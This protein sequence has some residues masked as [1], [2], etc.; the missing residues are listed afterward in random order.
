MV[1][2]LLSQRKLDLL[3][4]L[5]SAEVSA[6]HLLF[7]QLIFLCHY[8]QILSVSYTLGKTAQ[9]GARALVCPAAF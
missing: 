2:K 9:Y 4:E 5:V 3:D 6:F 8:L 7:S 1:S